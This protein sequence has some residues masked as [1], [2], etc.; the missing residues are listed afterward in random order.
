MAILVSKQFPMDAT[1]TEGAYVRHEWSVDW[2]R[3]GHSEGQIF[4][5]IYKSADARQAT[6]IPG[7]EHRVVVP[8]ASEDEAVQTLIDE[9]K[10]IIQ[11]LIAKEYELSKLLD[12]VLGAGEDLV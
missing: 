3:K 6:G 4:F 7:I 5:T 1:V 11:S 12:P 2:H 10:A 9:R 8:Q